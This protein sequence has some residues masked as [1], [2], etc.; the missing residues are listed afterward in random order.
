MILLSE[1]WVSQ[2][3][4]RVNMKRPL[5]GSKNKSEIK[6]PVAPVRHTPER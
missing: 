4:E 1:T 6:N 5:E 2:V 3:T